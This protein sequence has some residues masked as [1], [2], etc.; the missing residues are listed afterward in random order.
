MQLRRT[1]DRNDPRL[2]CQQPGKR[3][4]SRRRL[5]LLRELANQI[6]QP[7]IHFT[8]LRRKARNY[9]AEVSLVKLRVFADLAG[10]ETLAQ[11]AERN[12]SDSEFLE[13]RYDFGFRFSPPQ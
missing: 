4:L 10:E 8:V 13:C 6:N 3:D 9:V 12:E 5:C 1:R 11:R 7:L 2:L